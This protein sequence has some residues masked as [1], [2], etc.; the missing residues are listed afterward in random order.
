MKIEIP[1][2]VQTLIKLLETHHFQ[3]FVVGGAIR[4]TLLNL[5]VHDYDLTTEATPD[6]MLEVFKDYP[7]I[8]TG[9]KFGTL[10]VLIEHHPIEV[11]TFRSENSYIDHRCP[12]SVQ[13]SKSIQEDCKRRDF[14]IN[15]LCTRGDDEILDFFNGID[16]LHNEIIRC[17]GNPVERF[18]E[19]ALRILRALRF[20]GRLSFTIEENTAHAIHAQKDLLKEISVERIHSE[21][22]GILQ[23]HSLPDIITNYP[24]VI[25][26]FLPELSTSW[27]LDNTKILAQSKGDANIRMAILLRN[28]QSPK[29]ILKRL[30][31]STD[32]IN[33]II[34]CIQNMHVSLTNKIE[35]KYL[36]SKLKIPFDTYHSFRCVID[37]SYQAS[38]IHAYYQEIINNHE[39]YSLKDLVINGNTLKQYGYLGKQIADILTDCLSDVIENPSHNTSDYL[40]NKLKNTR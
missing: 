10:T 30:T 9:K 1:A 19:D 38:T 39:P 40:H 8:E 5:P 27:L 29:Q 16:D 17:I 37:D 35:L 15:A 33:I 36:L 28:Q 23:T 22:I 4:N 2:Y 14:T 18:D 13:Y 21:W 34:T 24:D 11:T 32:E 26:V 3:A 31:Y 7:V 6:Q 25:Q 12:S 20:A